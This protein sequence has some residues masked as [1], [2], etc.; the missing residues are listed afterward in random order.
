MSQS[1][2]ARA[3]SCVGVCV[4]QWQSE[5]K[6]VR[7]CLPKREREKTRE[8]AGFWRCDA[9]VEAKCGRNV[10]EEQHEGLHNR[11]SFWSTIWR[12][13]PRAPLSPWRRH[14]RDCPGRGFSAGHTELLPRA[15]V[16]LVGHA[17]A[18]REDRLRGAEEVD[19]RN[20]PSFP[21]LSSGLCVS[22]SS[23][24]RRATA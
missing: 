8:R 23:T 17:E 4:C 12:E 5:R 16:A 13:A 7:A 6:N 11:S 22:S 1:R 3:S 15:G 18:R 9:V 21:P 14:P 19:H 2:G 10:V 20:D 24:A